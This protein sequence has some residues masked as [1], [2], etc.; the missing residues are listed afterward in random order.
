MTVE[1]VNNLLDH[2]YKLGWKL[3]NIQPAG[4]EKEACFYI[5][6]EN[7]NGKFVT[8]F[9]DGPNHSLHLARYFETLE[10]GQVDLASKINV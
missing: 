5:L 3:I 1:M 4:G 6:V 9:Y 10:D 8:Y 7:H 2:V